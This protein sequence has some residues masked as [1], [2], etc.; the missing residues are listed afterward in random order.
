M[1]DT[2]FLEPFTSFIAAPTADLGRLDADVAVFGFPLVTPYDMRGASLHS[3]EAPGAVRRESVWLGDPVD[4]YDFDLGGTVFDGKDV[5]LV[6]CGDVRCEP[7][8]FPA[9]R[10][11]ATAVTR[12]ILEAGAV[13]VMLGG[14]DSAPIPFF[15]AFE[16][17]G[18]FT[19]VQVDAHIDWR[20]EVNG[21]TEG[22]SSTMRRASEMP[23][24]G[25]M[26]QVG[27]RGT[28]SARAEEVRDA[29]ARG[30][31]LVS[32]REVHESGVG[33]ALAR[34]P[35]GGEIIL[36]ID[37]DGI[38]PSVMPGVNAPSP[39]GL[40]HHQATALVQGLAR[41]GRIAGFDIVE[42]APAK[43]VNGISA[44]AAARLIIN[45]VGAMVRSGQLPRRR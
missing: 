20:H 31:T 26:V 28:G 34:V 24:I 21:I 36:T 19:L 37:C 39:G 3:A 2:I 9:S 30:V 32:A 16:G 4:R 13:P 42:L 25:R 27:Q 22:Y 7:T 18:P 5:R 44:Y 12:R 43:D 38:D 33:A 14:D 17:R 41:K 11:R 35:E 15:R 40:T 8:D 10:A 45:M 6:D 1:A 23:W 29:L